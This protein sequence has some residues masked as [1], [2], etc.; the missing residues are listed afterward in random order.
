MLNHS[1]SAAVMDSDS[2]L[3]NFHHRHVMNR[4]YLVVDSDAGDVSCNELGLESSDDLNS[5]VCQRPL[6]RRIWSRLD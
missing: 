5:V 3:Y 2:R 6:L 4:V 1:S